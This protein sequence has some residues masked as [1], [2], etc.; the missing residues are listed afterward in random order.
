MDFLNRKFP[1]KWTGRGGPITWPPCLPDLT[2]LDIFFWGYIKDTVYMSPLATTLSEFF[3]RIRD[4]VAIVTLD[5]L[6]TMWTEIEYR[7][8]IC[9]A[10][11][12]A[13]TE[14]L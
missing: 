7:Y 4:A 8:D 14:L 12:G 6:N 1:E 13:L 5:V 2:S 11:H 3:G 9:Q 10:T